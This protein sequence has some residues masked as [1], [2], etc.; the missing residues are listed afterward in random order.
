MSMYANANT[1]VHRLNTEGG[2]DA[3]SQLTQTADKRRERAS[4][5]TERLAVES[6]TERDNRF[7][8]G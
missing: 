8:S 3:A 5:Q 1:C 2:R 6:P 7:Y 4:A